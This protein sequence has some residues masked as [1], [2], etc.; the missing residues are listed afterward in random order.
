MYITSRNAKNVERCVVTTFTFF[1][2]RNEFFTLKTA[3]L[4]FAGVFCKLLLNDSTYQSAEILLLLRQTSRATKTLYRFISFLLIEIASL[5]GQ[6]C[7]SLY[8]DTKSS[9]L[10]ISVFVDRFQYNL[11]IIQ[12]ELT[13]YWTTLYI[14][15]NSE[16]E[17]AAVRLSFLLYPFV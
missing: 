17:F 9:K 7:D 8:N 1:D 3:K 4:W 2:A 16:L 12:H 14:N 13:F 5:F 6:I 11:L 10:S 15:I